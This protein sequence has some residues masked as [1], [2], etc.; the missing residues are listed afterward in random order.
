MSLSVI[1]G[2]GFVKGTR[3]VVAPSGSETIVGQVPVEG[4]E[5]FV[6][7]DR[8]R[9]IAQS[10]AIQLGYLLEDTSIDV[11]NSDDLIQDRDTAS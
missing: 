8:P 10:V 2:Q 6:R 1:E 9:E 4:G 3:L 11:I 7:L 5:Q